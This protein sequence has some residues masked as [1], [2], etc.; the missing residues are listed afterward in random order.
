MYLL[1]RDTDGS[2]KLQR[3]VQPCPSKP[4]WM[5]IWV[6]MTKIHSHVMW[7]SFIKFSSIKISWAPAAD[8]KVPRK[9]GGLKTLLASPWNHLKA[10]QFNRRRGKLRQDTEVGSETLDGP[11]RATL[12]KQKR[13]A[14]GRLAN[15]DKYAS[16]YS[17]LKH[18]PWQ[19]W[20]DHGALIYNLVFPEVWAH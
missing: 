17:Y 10:S 14:T 8:Q 9:L 1:L 2:E 13:H 12:G 15:P 20:T 7:N 18:W 3:R 19:V 16:N 5:A 4:Q 11:K 6:Q